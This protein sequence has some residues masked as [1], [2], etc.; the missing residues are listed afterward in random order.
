M[1]TTSVSASNFVEGVDLSFKIILGVS[2]FFLIGITI[3]MIYFIV[4]YRRSKNPSAKQIEGSNTLEI[5]W[6][7]IPLGLVMVMFY[8][9]W[10]GWKPMTEVPD[11]ALD[12]KSVARMWSWTFEYDNGKFSDTLYV[13][14]NKPIKID[15][16]SLDVLHSLYIPAFRVKSDMVPGMDKDMWFTPQK[17]GTYDL[18]CAEYCGLRHSYMSSA[19]VVLPEDT[20]EKWYGDTTGV[21]PVGGDEALM[22]GRVVINKNGCNACHTFDGSKLA[23]PSYKGLYGSERVVTTGGEKRTVIADEEYLRRSI[24]QPNA[25]IVDGYNKGL[26]LSYKDQITEKELDQIIEYLKT[27]K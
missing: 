21:S 14:V 2:L 10:A 7:V 6:T 27:L 4:R 26:M 18:F 12:V 5:V 25:D 9:G 19:V 15:L 11:D 17:T 20:F 16:V 23:G 24:Y 8:Y 13:P 3:V 22:P 1:D